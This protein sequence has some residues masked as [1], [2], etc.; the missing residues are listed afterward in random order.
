LGKSHLQ[1]I[2]KIIF[3]LLKI[4]GLAQNNDL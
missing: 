2:S 4:P 3:S 1:F